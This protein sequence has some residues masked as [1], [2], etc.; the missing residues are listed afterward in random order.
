MVMC[1][2][3]NRYGIV[4]HIRADSMYVV[5]VSYTIASGTLN[6]MIIETGLATIAPVP[7]PPVIG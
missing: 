7:A 5:S 2:T 1:I 3:C 4:C 6:C